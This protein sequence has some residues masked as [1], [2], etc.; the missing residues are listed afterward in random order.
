[1]QVGAA[2]HREILTHDAISFRVRLGA[3]DL[4]RVWA[5]SFSAWA[6]FKRTAICRASNN[7]PGKGCCR[8]R[9]V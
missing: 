4:G 6:P 9:G 5:L 2:R 3:W 7:R 1:M 8:F